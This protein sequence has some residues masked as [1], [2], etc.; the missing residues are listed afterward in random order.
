MRSANDLLDKKELIIRESVFC[1]VKCQ[2]GI[3]CLVS[4]FA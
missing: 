4:R 2:V 1:Q 3:I